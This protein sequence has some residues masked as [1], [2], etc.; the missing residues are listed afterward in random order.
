[1][2]CDKIYIDLKKES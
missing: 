1:M 2:L